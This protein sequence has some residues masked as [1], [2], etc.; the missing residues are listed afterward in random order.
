MSTVD[1]MVVKWSMDSSKFDSGINSMNKQMNVLKS[2]FKATSIN[3]KNFGSV[4]E[5]LKNKQQYLSNAMSI[6][7]EK[8]SA[9]RQQYEKQKQA[10]G[11]NSTET[12]NLAIKLNN[13]ISYYNT[14]EGQLKDTTEELKK[15]STQ[16]SNTS[17]N[18]ENISKK[19]SSF[20]SALSG[21]GQKLTNT[22]TTSIKGIGSSAI[23]SYETVKEG[24]DNLVKATGATGESAEELGE[25]YKNIASNSSADFSTIG[26]ALGEV[27]T[28]FA[29]TGET[30]EKCT[31][32][33]LKFAKINNTDTVT[34][35]QL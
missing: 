22:L 2:E 30:A 4:E 29:F 15:Q 24:M 21:I 1:E 7:K 32:Q 8:V 11:E 20:G 17:Q 10:T 23:S 34:S 16:L 31:E 12:Q 9:L 6:Q 35:I 13:A 19:F 18:L 33:F 28:R 3:L 26:S 27:N 25:T 5:Q 14:L